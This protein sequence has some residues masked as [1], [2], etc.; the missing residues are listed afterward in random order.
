MR[1]NHRRKVKAR[2]EYPYTNANRHRVEQDA[3][4]TARRRMGKLL[5]QGDEALRRCKAVTP[6][7][8]H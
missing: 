4:N 5:A 1:T 2:Q 8:S 7:Y 3:A 6:N